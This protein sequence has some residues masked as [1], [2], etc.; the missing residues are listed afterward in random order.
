M[1]DKFTVPG[2]QLEFCMDMAYALTQRAVFLNDRMVWK[3]IA[4]VGQIF[5]I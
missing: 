1:D 2:K 5:I 3:P 4:R